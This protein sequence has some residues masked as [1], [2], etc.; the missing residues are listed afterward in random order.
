V[1]E[2]GF[3]CK[4]FRSLSPKVKGSHGSLFLFRLAGNYTRL[5]RLQKHSSQL[6]RERE[7]QISEPEAEHYSVPVQRLIKRKKIAEILWL[8]NNFP[9]W[10]RFTNAF[11][12]VTNHSLPTFGA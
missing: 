1:A 5:E 2:E 3:G 4:G 6:I 8:K 10:V 11:V 12:K 9:Q 7:Y